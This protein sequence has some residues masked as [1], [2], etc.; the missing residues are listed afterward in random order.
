MANTTKTR[1]GRGSGSKKTPDDQVAWVPADKDY[2]LGIDRGK[3][4][5]RNPQGKRLASVPKWLKETPL[6]DQLVALCEWLI[7]HRSECL[8]RIELWMLRSLP[9]PRSAIEAVWPDSDWREL[10][11]NLVIMPVDASGVGDS[12]QTGLLRDIKPGEGVG[13]VDRD[14]E[15]QWIA[16]ESVLIPHPILIDGLDDL[17]EIAADLNFSQ[18]VE[19]LFRPVFQATEAQRRMASIREFSD[20]KFAQLNFCASLCRRLGY[21]IRGGYACAKVWENGRPIEARYWVGEGDPFYETYTGELVFVNAEQVPQPIAEIGPVTFSEGLRMAS[22]IYAKR[23]VEKTEE[24][25]Q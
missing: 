14:G 20:G 21:A 15:S 16:A 4:I 7:D 17:R 22:A 3:L 19:Q 2:A 24:N 13:V 25:D 1:P 5:A 23:E 10:L 8:Q 18:S 11:T 12:Q 6:A 9:V